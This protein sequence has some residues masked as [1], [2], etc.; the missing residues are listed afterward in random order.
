MKTTTSNKLY[1][2]ISQTLPNA[3][4]L[5][6][7]CW[8]AIML[9]FETESCKWS[10]HFFENIYAPIPSKD[11]PFQHST[12]WGSQHNGVDLCHLRRPLPHPTWGSSSPSSIGPCIR[13]RRLHSIDHGL[14]TWLHQR[15][16]M[17]NRWHRTS[18]LGLLGASKIPKMAPFHKKSPQLC[19]G[20]E[21]PD[22]V[23][24]Y[25]T[26]QA[27]AVANTRGQVTGFSVGAPYAPKLHVTRRAPWRRRARLMG[28]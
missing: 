3:T 16:P 21:C 9:S 15:K 22:Q 5:T 23:K 20:H 11:P 17:V 2:K 19:L 10:R 27:P 14:E 24:H 1:N 26:D 8:G 13:G 25:D 18:W 7:H 6:C 12:F 28:R 4:Q